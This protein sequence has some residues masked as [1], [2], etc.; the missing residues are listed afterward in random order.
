M[1]VSDS[2]TPSSQRVQLVWKREGGIYAL[3][4]EPHGPNEHI[5]THLQG[6]RIQH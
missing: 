3:S 1:F 6:S 4:K 2:A 5:E